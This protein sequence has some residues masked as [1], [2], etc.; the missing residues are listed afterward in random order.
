MVMERVRPA[1]VARES[2]A[3]TVNENVPRVV[4]VPPITPR[5]SCRPGGSVPETSVHA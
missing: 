1:V 2:V 3:R 5:E 4:G